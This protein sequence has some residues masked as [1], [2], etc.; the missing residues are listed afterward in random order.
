MLSGPEHR[1]ELVNDS[2][3]ELIG[4]RDVLQRCVAEAV[5]EV[6]EQ[7]FIALLDNLFRTGEPFVGSA[8]PR[9]RGQDNPGVRR[10]RLPADP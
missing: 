10:L 9:S 4:R 3:S 5:P 6:V 8:A 7:G 1:F 2:Y